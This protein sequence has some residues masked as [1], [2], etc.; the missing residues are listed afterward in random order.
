MVDTGYAVY[1][2]PVKDIDALVA[3]CQFSPEAYVLVEQ[4]PR[5]VVTSA[6]KRQNLLLFIQLKELAPDQYRD[7]RLKDYTS[8]RVFDQY[9]EV[10]WEWIEQERQGGPFQA[11]YVGPE[12][13][14][15]Q[16]PLN[17]CDKQSAKLGETRNTRYFLFGLKLDTE[18]INRI[19]PPAQEGDYAQLRIPRLLRYPRLLN[20]EK[21]ERLQL[22]VREYIDEG[23]GNVHLFRF[24]GLE[25]EGKKL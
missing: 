10:R 7:I 24:R 20:G 23:T 14:R 22:T 5:H 17:K 3:S 25:P 6:K 16:F 2:G 15:E 13:E 11:I 1:T 12:R 9:A 19:G 18:D 8:G 4:T 21:P